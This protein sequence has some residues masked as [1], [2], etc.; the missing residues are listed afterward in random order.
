MK[1]FQRIDEALV[2]VSADKKGPTFCTF[3]NRKKDSVIREQL[4]EEKNC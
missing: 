1:W 4:T 2:L 3:Q